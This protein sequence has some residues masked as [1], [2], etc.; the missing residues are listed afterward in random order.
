MRTS[1]LAPLLEIDPWKSRVGGSSPS[2]HDAH[3]AMCHLKKAPHHLESDHLPRLPDLDDALPQEGHKGGVPGENP[4]KP[5]K[6]RGYDGIRLAVE[7]RPFCRNDRYV[8]QDRAIFLA[9][10]T[11]SS[12]PPCM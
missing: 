11:T 9:C 2:C 6:G 10:A 1:K 4:Y 12:I 7:Y 8:H 3:N 5:V